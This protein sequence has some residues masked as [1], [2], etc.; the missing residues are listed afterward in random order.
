VRKCESM[1]ACVYGYKE[2]LPWDDPQLICSTT[3]GRGV[4]SRETSCEIQSL[5]S[6]FRGQGVGDDHCPAIADQSFLQIECEAQDGCFFEW[7]YGKWKEDACAANC[8]ES[9]MPR[10]VYCEK[11]SRSGDETS[12]VGTVSD[13]MCLQAARPKST[14][15]CY[16]TKTCDY[17]WGKEAWG[18]CHPAC[19]NSKKERHTW[20]LR[21]DDQ[22]VEAEECT[23]NNAG[24]KPQEEQ[25]CYSYATCSYAWHVKGT[26]SGGTCMDK[27]Q[28]GDETGVDCGGSCPDCLVN[29]GWS[30]FGA[31]SACSASCG[32]G[33]MTA[34]RTCTNP[35]P[36]NGGAE[37]VGQSVLSKECNKSDCQVDF[38]QM[39]SFTVQEKRFK[40]SI[41]QGKTQVV[42]RI[43][44]GKANVA[45]KLTANADIDLLLETEDGTPLISY[46]EPNLNWGSSYFKYHNM[47]IR[48]CTDGCAAPLDMVFKGDGQTHTMGT[49][50]SYST[51]YIFISQTTEELV[52]KASGYE[53]GSG[54]VSFQF[55]CNEDCGVCT[56]V[57]GQVPDPRPLVMP[58]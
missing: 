10:D 15:D 6:P 42:T 55:D 32:A 41:Q 27:Q 40:V 12:A 34:S 11:R 25:R 54:V 31:W 8:G 44:V 3:C 18:D 47:E 37:C 5:D 56:P 13:S 52:L 21:S 28:N 26:V 36:A 17:S 14:K 38:G 43:P 29:G 20:C 46:T 16:S 23:A 30:D 22:Q 24:D 9:T 53:V 58:N 4:R 50:S 33:Q 45:V 1:D 57:F 2:P 48:S 19:G 39:C 7:N 51:E 35:K 49:T